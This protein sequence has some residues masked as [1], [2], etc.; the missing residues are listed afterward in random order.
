MR[1]ELEKQ[2]ETDFPFMQRDPEN[3][4]R[5]T[6]KQWGCEC[7]DGWYELLRELCQSITDRYGQ[8][9]KEPDL[10]VLQVKEKFAGLRFYYSYEDSPR[11]IQAFDFLGD[12]TSVRLTPDE[13]ADE[14][15]R[16]LRRDIAE[17]VRT[18]EKKSVTICEFCGAPG[19]KRKDLPWIY[20]LCDSC[21]KA[22]LEQRASNKKRSGSSID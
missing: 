12:G 11:R 17:I 20:T 18:F 9:G 14:D 1:N 4:E 10:I 6:Y 22:H 5:N 15:T 13:S 3:G 2:L 8:D 19:E 7:G 16:K 21:Y